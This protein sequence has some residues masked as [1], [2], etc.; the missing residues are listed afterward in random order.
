MRRSLKPWFLT[1]LAFLFSLT[2]LDY[3]VHYTLYSYGLQFSLAWAKPYWIAL[4][5]VFL[6][7]ALNSAYSFR[8]RATSRPQDKYL[9][10]LIF[11]TILVSSLG[12]FL[13]FFWWVIHGSLPPMDFVWHWS[14]FY[15]FF[16]YE[17]TT[18]HQL[19]YTLAWFIIIV[20]LWIIYGWLSRRSET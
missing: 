16:N 4:N 13:D 12:G 7:A 9:S 3:I 20:T 6:S 5:V 18:R 15:W 2:Y 1:F 17:W 11:F 14:V 19:I 10:F 8:L